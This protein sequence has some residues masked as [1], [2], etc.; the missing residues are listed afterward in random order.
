MKIKK[1]F[2]VF[3]GLFLLFLLL[4]P[5]VLAVSGKP[6]ATGK[7]I[8]VGN[9][10]VEGRLRACQ[11][12]QQGII[13]RM[14]QLEK[15]AENMLE[16]FSAIQ[17]RVVQYYNEKVVPSG[18][19]VANYDTLIAEIQTKKTA[20]QTAI[21]QARANSALFSCDEDDPKGQLKKFGD[22]M[23]AVKSALKEYRTS[24][25]NLIVAVRSL[26]NNEI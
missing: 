4:A 7:P 26:G 14:D 18:K 3:L 23:R 17:D 6:K 13:K 12:K 15:M 1:Q 2:S 8:G 11:A 22:D 25:R 24:I 20:V 9:T 5:S 16:K 21:D 10:K 19:T